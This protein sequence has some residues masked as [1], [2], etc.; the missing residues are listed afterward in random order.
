VGSQWAVRP[1]KARLCYGF[2][3]PPVEVTG[4]K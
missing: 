4:A 3:P 2:Y 1:N